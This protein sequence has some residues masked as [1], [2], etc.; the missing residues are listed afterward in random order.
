MSVFGLRRERFLDERLA[1]GFAEI[2]VHV[3]DAALPAWPLLLDALKNCAVEMEVLVHEGFRQQDG[4]GV[5]HVPA[6]IRLN[7]SERRGGQDLVE[8]REEVRLGYVDSRKRRRADAAVVAR[9]VEGRRERLE[10]GGRLLVVDAFRIAPRHAIERRLGER[11]FDF[12]H[13][14]GVRR[15]ARGRSAGKREQLAHVLDVLLA[16]VHGSRIVLEVVVAIGKAEAALVGAGDD[17]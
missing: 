7:V 12:H 6:Q 10:L 14:V 8:G 15:C 17:R 5:H 1:K 4:V 11:R 13:R 3:G 9:P 2:A 16:D